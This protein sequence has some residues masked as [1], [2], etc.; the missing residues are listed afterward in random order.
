MDEEVLLAE[1]P[2]RT[3]IKMRLKESCM[4]TSLMGVPRVLQESSHL[5]L[6]IFWA[7]A[8]LGCS[9][10]GIY[11]VIQGIQSYLAF[12]AYMSVNRYNEVPTKFPM[13]S[14]CSMNSFNFDSSAVQS[15]LAAYSSDFYY[16]GNNFA[17]LYE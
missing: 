4:D 12:S 6:R 13:V 8:F 3:L 14:F 7:L 2:A 1:A 9:A 10:A 11:F 17:S 5:F 16:S 15:Y